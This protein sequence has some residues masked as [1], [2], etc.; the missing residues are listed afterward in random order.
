MTYNKP[1][2]VKLNSARTVINGD[3]KLGETY[4]DNRT[5]LYTAT[6]F[7]YESDE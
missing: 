4:F 2:L 5:H 7:A 3:A 6:I 1:E